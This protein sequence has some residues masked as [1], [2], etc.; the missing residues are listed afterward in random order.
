VETAQTDDD[1]AKKRERR[2]NAIF[3]RHALEELITCRRRLDALL[4]SLSLLLAD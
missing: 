2:A 1:V 4:E 3:K